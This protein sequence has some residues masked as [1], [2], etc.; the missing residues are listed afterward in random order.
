MFS[1]YDARHTFPD[2]LSR[3][4]AAR[5]IAESV[6]MGH[7]LETSLLVFYPQLA[8]GPRRAGA[9]PE[10]RATWKQFRKA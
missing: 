7:R 5:E 3:S 4:A 2:L 8:A 9:M 1:L 10:L 6:G